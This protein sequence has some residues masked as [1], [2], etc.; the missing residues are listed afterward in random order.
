MHFTTEVIK[1]SKKGRLRQSWNVWYFKNYGHKNHLYTFLSI[2]ALLDKVS[3]WQCFPRKYIS[4]SIALHVMHKNKNIIT[5]PV[6]DGCW[7]TID[8]ISPYDPEY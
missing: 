2:T 5:A 1:M 6:R 3:I 4:I 8:S 7:G